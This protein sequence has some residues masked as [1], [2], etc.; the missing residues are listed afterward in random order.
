MMKRNK[1]AL[2]FDRRRGLHGILREYYGVEKFEEAVELLFE[3][4]GRLADFG[5]VEIKC[6]DD[7]ISCELSELDAF[8]EDLQ[9]IV[10]TEIEIAAGQYKESPKQ[11]QMR[12]PFFGMMEKFWDDEK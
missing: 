11:L 4:L 12:D 2:T 6:V 8:F 3:D 9:T 1:A 5:S 10:E 7:T